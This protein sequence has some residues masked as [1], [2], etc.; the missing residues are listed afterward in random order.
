MFGMTVSGGGE[1][2]FYAAAPA[3][4]WDPEAGE[5]TDVYF[6]EYKNG[7]LHLAGRGKIRKLRKS[8]RTFNVEATIRAFRYARAT[9][10]RMVQ[11]YQSGITVQ[12]MT[13]GK[14]P[15]NEKWYMSTRLTGPDTAGWTMDHREAFARRFLWVGMTD[16]AAYAT[17]G[18]PES[19]LKGDNEVRL[20]FDLGKTGATTAN[21]SEEMGGAMAIVEE[22]KQRV[23]VKNGIV[24]ELDPEQ[25][26][27]FDK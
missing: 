15:R 14:S 5:G 21:L 17:L 19:K 27:H 24:T 23:S 1:A 7:A 4:G 22:L 2:R 16:W 11:G 9:Q 6:Y 18:Q 13:H 8:R 12:T 10:R 3:A 25:K 26:V 20:I